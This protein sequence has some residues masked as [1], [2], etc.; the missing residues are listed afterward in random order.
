[1]GNTLAMIR[2]SGEEPETVEYLKTPP[3]RSRLEELIAAMGPS[4]PVTRE[5]TPYAELGLGVPKWTDDELLDFMMAHPILINRPIVITPKGSSSAVRRRRPSTFSRI[6]ISAASS[7]RR[8]G[9]RGA[10]S[11]KRDGG[12]PSEANATAARLRPVRRRA[13][14]RGSRQSPCR[15]GLI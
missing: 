5:R 10:V 13:R 11:R 3:T 8:R 15:S 4:A 7:R 6:R 2:R 1:L 12:D 9:L 14:F